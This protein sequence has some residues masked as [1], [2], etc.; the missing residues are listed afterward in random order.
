MHPDIARVPLFIVFYGRLEEIPFI[1]QES[2]TCN[3]PCKEAIIFFKNHSMGFARLNET[4]TTS[5]VFIS[6]HADKWDT[7]RFH[8]LS[9]NYLFKPLNLMRDW[10]KFDKIIRSLTK[11]L[12]LKLLTGIRLLVFGIH[13]QWKFPG[14]LAAFNVRNQNKQKDNFKLG[15]A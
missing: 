13:L 15:H 9:C 3:R 12:R 10:R 6:G 7:L 8:S 4:R 5:E 11:S 1:F 2:Y 14:N